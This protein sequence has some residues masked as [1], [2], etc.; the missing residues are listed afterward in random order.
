VNLSDVAVATI[1][2]VR[3]ADD[4]RSLRQSLN[5]LVATGIPLAVSDGGSPKRFVDWM[6]HL[7][8]VTVGRS[9]ESLVGQV[10]ASLAAADK[11][12]RPFILYTEPDKRSFFDGG[13]A[14][15]VARA[16]IARSIG[17]QLASRSESG[18]ATFPRFQ[19]LAEAGANQLC[20]EMIGAD[21][22]YFYG[23]FLVRRELARLVFSAADDLG[24]GWRPFL[25][26]TAKR[27]GYRVVGIAGDFECPR[28]QRHEEDRDKEYR[29]R[30][31]ADNVRG[32]LDGI[33]QQLT[34]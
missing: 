8:T 20:R 4:E 3:G 32:L 11:T 30:Q 14:A 13:L 2:R 23:P 16:S 21:I 27:V 33:T 7:P 25:F 12:G 19:R 28:D 18:F 9:G 22:D 17:V 29:M 31:F 34:R 26:T 15:F 5:A 1:T 24:W 10:R 6:K